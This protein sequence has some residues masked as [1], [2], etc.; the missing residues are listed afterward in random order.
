[1][2]K[3]QA[4]LVRYDDV[5]LLPNFSPPVIGTLFEKDT[6]EGPAIDDAY[7]RSNLRYLSPITAD[8]RRVGQV[9]D[10][11]SFGVLAY[12]LITGSTIDGGP[13]S[14]GDADI[15]LLA[16]IHRHMT[17]DILPPFSY[18]ERE[19]ELGGDILGS[20]MVPLPKELSDVVMKCLARDLD[21][22]Y[23]SLDALAYDLRRLGQ[24]CRS[25]GD[26]TK[27]TVGQIDHMSR[28]SLPAR[29]IHRDNEMEELCSAWRQI[30]RTSRQDAPEHLNGTSTVRVINVWGLSGSGKTR[31]VQTWAKDLEGVRHG[32]GCL[33]A[34]SKLDEFS[35]RPISS[36]V[37]VFQS[38]LDRVLTDPKEDAKAWSKKIRV[39]LGQQFP[40]FHSLLSHE[41]QR[42]LM[43]GEKAPP[44][45]QIDWANFVPAFKG[46]AKRLIQ[47]FAIESRPL[48]CI[49]D[50]LQWM[51][52][53]EVSI[54]RALL[55]GSHPVN[56]VLLV[57]L[58][59]T[60]T[61]TA[62]PLADLLSGHSVSL[63][64][65][66]LP[67]E[68][69]SDFVQSCLPTTVD[70]LGT[71]SSLLYEE[72][73]GSPLY[74]RSLVVSLVRDCVIY[75]DFEL[76]L[77]RFDPLALQAHLSD[78]GVDAYL[79]KVQQGL[80]AWTREALQFLACLPV[81]GCRLGLLA[82]LCK[83]SE[84]ALVTRLAPAQAIGVIIMGGNHVRFAHDRPRVS[85]R[86]SRSRGIG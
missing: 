40:V 75:F 52:Q 47:I 54:W 77:W 51:R 18:L 5:A 59:R 42:L 61:S 20:D 64:I 12:E 8:V 43:M 70:G 22:R 55:E 81:S 74:L 62:P 35:S 72:T 38:L 41:Y 28:F 67:E 1:M 63:H 82:D 39:A 16:D 73:L 13:E 15:D 66:R 78:N 32:L 37:Q 31:L 33:I 65:E 29:P 68:G 27:F 2:R 3:G 36:F 71:L 58:Y 46:W 79:Q 84:E 50:D 76:L 25:G 86:A 34:Q 60:E 48:V 69:V 30:D 57:S 21:E 24:I 56:H 10:I 9:G 6:L 7:I 45:E 17:C 53:D 26:L 14:P 11:Y 49:I 23:G 80:P 4:V 19:A 85:R 44:V 83:R